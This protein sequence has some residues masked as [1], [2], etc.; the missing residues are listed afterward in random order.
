M[1][2]TYG[3]IAIPVAATTPAG[4]PALTKLG[5]YLKAVVNVKALTAWTAARPRGIAAE[6]LPIRFVRLANPEE[7][8]FNDKDLPA[9]YL[10]REDGD[11]QQRTTDWHCDE[12]HIKLIWALPSGTQLQQGERKSF[13]NA[14]AKVIADALERGR[15]PNWADAGDP[16]VAAASIAASVNSI[17]LSAATQTVAQTLS[18][19]ALDGARGSATFT[20]TGLRL[21]PTVTTTLVGTVDDPGI[22]GPGDDDE[23]VYDINTAIVWTVVDWYG[24]TKTLSKRLT[25]PFGGE[26]LTVPEDVARITSIYVPPQLS[27]LGA[28]QF[29]TAAFVGRGSALRTRCSFD[30]LDTGKWTRAKVAIEVLDD[31]QRVTS[32]LMYPALAMTLTAVE[33][34][35]VDLTDATR[36]YPDAGDLDTEKVTAGQANLLLAARTLP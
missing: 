27:E 35:V 11:F 34:R 17:K 26:T 18:G 32:R 36:F 3:A 22:P 23:A 28:F 12:S 31:E 15:D 10:W 19:V 25:L 9:L 13:F 6:Q 2:D 21:A 4:D 1:A 5:N 16:D 7:E 20:P 14:L 24:R 29:G 33:Q 8:G 30:R